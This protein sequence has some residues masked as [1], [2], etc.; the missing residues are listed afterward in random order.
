[1][2]QL[3][4]VLIYELAKGVAGRATDS[5]HLRA[6]QAQIQ[7]TN[8]IYFA[9]FRMVADQN[10]VA[11]EALLRTLFDSA[12]N[13]IV[14]AKHSEKLQDFIRNGQFTHL[15]L[16]RFTDVMPEKIKPL[17]AATENDWKALFQEFKSSEWHKLGTKDS[18]I[19]AEYEAEM[20]NK[21]FRRASSYAHAEPYITVR[22]K[23]ATWK[24]WCIDASL[25][26]WKN[27]TI[28]VYGL[29]CNAMLHMLAIVNREFKLGL[30]AEFEKPLALVK[31]FKI[32]HIEIIKQAFANEDSA[33]RQAAQAGDK[34]T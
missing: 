26:R 6:V 5:E 19:E 11:A 4:G 23:D 2:E 22:P 27:V 25:V 13:C 31:A 17:V 14:L 29:A 10:G 24:N 15:R 7:V 16:I 33:I 34:T 30:D 9:I 8:Q 32:K 20:Y 3:E 18:F 1:M 21:Y 12:I 28:G